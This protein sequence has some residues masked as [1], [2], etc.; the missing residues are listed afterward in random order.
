L[1]FFLTKALAEA[2]GLSDKFKNV[3]LAREPIQKGTRHFLIPK[4]R[5]PIPKTEI[6]GDNNGDSLIDIGAEL[7]Q[8]LRTLF[9]KRNETDFI[10]NNQIMF[11]EWCHELGEAQ[12]MLRSQ[13]VIDQ[14][15]CAKEANL[16]ALFTG[17]KSKSCGNM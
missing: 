12:F 8:Q 11:Q 9:R 3:P 13:E 2:V 10:Q 5:N 14:T 15:C 6:C 16:F 1:L 4:N 17:C 7:K